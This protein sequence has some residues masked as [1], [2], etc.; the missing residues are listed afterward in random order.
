MFCSVCSGI[1]TPTSDNSYFDD[2]PFHTFS[3]ISRK[4]WGIGDMVNS[5]KSYAPMGKGFTAAE[6]YA[7]R[8]KKV[9]STSKGA[10]LFYDEILQRQ[11]RARKKLRAIN[12]ALARDGGL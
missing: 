10:G 9:T 12:A 6:R 5:E 8:V 4:N 2:P 3:K 7:K 1:S 11:A